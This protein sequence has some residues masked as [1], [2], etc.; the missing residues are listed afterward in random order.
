MKDTREAQF[1][2]IWEACKVFDS[3]ETAST[4]VTS[5]EAGMFS[6]ASERK[7]PAAAKAR[8]KGEEPAA[9]EEKEAEEKPAEE[10]AA[11]SALLASGMAILALSL[12]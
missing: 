5:S 12:F 6:K 1:M 8:A 3:D 4:P 2:G 10:D 9:D 7:P 11:A